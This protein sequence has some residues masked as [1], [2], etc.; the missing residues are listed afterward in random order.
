M[1]STDATARDDGLAIERL[2][3]PDGADR[4]VLVHGFTQTA[5]C[6]GPFADLLAA[7]HDV[8]AVDAPGHGGSAAVRAD[9]V[10]G[11]D[12]L[13]RS[14]HRATY[15]GY[16]MGG[17]L[18]L[19]LALARPDLVDRLVLIGATAGIDDDAQRA[20]R[21]AADE[22]LADHL[23]AVGV[24]SFLAEWLAQPLFAGLSPSAAA[25]DERRRNT[26]GGLASSLRT[27]GT[28]SQRPLWD[29]L[30]RLAMPVLLLAGGDDRK[31]TDLA[32]RMAAAIG[33]NARVAVVPDTGHAAHLEA[34][35]RTAATVQR[36]LADP[37]A[38]P[39]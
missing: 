7:D 3:G 16:S 29:E 31:F 27:A 20:A 8:W 15:V 39:L 35:E 19:H 1:A 28:G 13:G 26:T 11:A 21:R 32:R 38:A 34:P 5:R 18:A 4:L 33:E 6:W 23:E 14:G 17:R 22:G 37:G 30:H 10:G 2:G 9:L 25:V 12:L 24:D 36:W